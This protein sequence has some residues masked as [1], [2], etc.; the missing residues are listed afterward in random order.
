MVSAIIKNRL[1]LIATLIVF[2]ILKIPHLHYAYYWDESIPYAV[3]IKKLYQHGISLMPNTID[4]VLSRGHPLLF[5]AAAAGWMHI[6]GGSNV[7]MHTFALTI[8]LLLLI[9]VFE[10]GL[11]LFNI[12]V[13]SI[14]LL[15][16]ITQEMVIVQSTT[17]LPEILVALLCFLSLIFYIRDQYLKA[18]ICLTLLFYT[19]ES[20]MIMGLVL[21][22]DGLIRLFKNGTDWKQRLVPVAAVGIPTL[23]IGIYFVVQKKVQGWYIFPSHTELILHEWQQFWFRFRMS[24]IHT[25]FYDNLK[26][27]QFLLLVVLAIVAA[28]KQKKLKFLAI[29]L[30]AICIFYFV[31]DMRAGR[32]LPSIPFFVV[33]A[34]TVI[35]FVFVYANL[36]DKSYQRRLIVLSA[37]FIFCFLCFSAVNFFT[38]RYLL[39]STVPM[40][41]LAAIFFDK[42][43]S[44]IGRKLYYVITPVLVAISA[45][46][47][48]NNKEHGDCDLGSYKALAVY[49]DVVDYFLRN[50][51]KDTYISSSLFLERE[52]LAD[53][54]VGFV[55]SA[56]AFGH[57][58][59]DIDDST[60]YVITDNIESDSRYEELKKNNRFRLEHRIANGNVW[61]EIYKRK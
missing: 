8:S 46:S 5:H 22:V 44:I 32:L 49:Q 30:P 58:R 47:I 52:H 59:W 3:A 48:I 24:V 17:V 41:M 14:A 34:L 26:Y 35:F 55:A 56:S 18:A 28:V 23:L 60:Q 29:L 19:K 61:A 31:E 25:Q 45:I 6:F 7:S 11:K 27:W 38:P 12:R 40:V 54:D 15:L 39:A 43:I 53:P 10:A 1:I 4:A 9:A 16:L 36:F 50:A 20:G 13:A 2:I 21:G 57:I 33:F 37:A 42:L 51:S